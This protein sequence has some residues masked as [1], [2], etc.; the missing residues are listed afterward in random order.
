MEKRIEE[1]FKILVPGLTKITH[2]AIIGKKSNEISL[3]RNVMIASDLKV[4]L[5]PPTI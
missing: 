3:M 5:S 1:F 4:L 2:T